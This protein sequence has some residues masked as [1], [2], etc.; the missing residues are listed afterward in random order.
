MPMVSLKTESEGP[1]VASYDC[2][3]VIYLNDDQVEALG[4]QG[5]PMP[6]TE[7]RL[8]CRAVV[9]HVTASGEEAEP[10]EEGEKPDVSLSLKI[11][12]MEATPQPGG[13]MADRLY[14]G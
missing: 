6:G 4:I 9:Q 7:F 11:T 10:G 1:E 8:V 3:P 13:S 2:C 14:G 12:D 5:L